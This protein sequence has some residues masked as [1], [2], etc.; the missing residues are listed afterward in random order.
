[1]HPDKEILINNEQKNE[2]LWNIIEFIKFIDKVDSLNFFLCLILFAKF[3]EDFVVVGSIKIYRIL[4]LG[5]FS[6]FSFLFFKAF[7]KPLKLMHKINWTK[8]NE[9]CEINRELSC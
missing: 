2:G 4:N 7:K 5:S 6:F 8:R 9:N 3:I 1:M